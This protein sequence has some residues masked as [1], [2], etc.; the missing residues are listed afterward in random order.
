M[1]AANKGRDV[2]NKAQTHRHR[3]TSPSPPPSLLPTLSHPPAPGHALSPTHLHQHALPLLFL[4]YFIFNVII[5]R[6]LFIL[7]LNYYNC[8]Y[9]WVTHHGYGY[10]YTPGP[11]MATRHS[12]PYP[13]HRYRLL[14][15]PGP[16]TAKNT[17]GLPVQIT[18][19]CRPIATPTPS[20][21]YTVWCL[22]VPR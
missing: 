21:L 3:Y 17:Q 20:A 1:R 11:K 15:G 19:R 4:L 2:V 9:P 10:E 16:G 6:L 18:S 12:Y 14:P 13:H 5:I 22:S 7:F 8:A